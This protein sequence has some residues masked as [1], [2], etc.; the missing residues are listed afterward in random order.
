MAVE[1]S[2]RLDDSGGI[3]SWT[4]DVWSQGHTA[5]PGYAGVP[6]L[7]A[8]AH[9]AHRLSGDLDLFCHRAEDVRALV[10]ALPSIAAESGVSVALVRDA[11]TFVRGEAA[12]RVRRLEEEGVQVTRLTEQMVQRPYDL[13]IRCDLARARVHSPDF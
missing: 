3:A 13:A 4:Y 1:V 7:L 10:Q 8:G 11:G 9:L 12:E 6:G 2:A 5:R